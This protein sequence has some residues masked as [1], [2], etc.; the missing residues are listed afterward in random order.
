MASKKISAVDLNPFSPEAQSI[1][2]TKRFSGESDRNQVR[3]TA[4]ALKE[5]G[6]VILK[7]RLSKTKLQEIKSELKLLH[8]GVSKGTS[9]FGGFETERVYNLVARTRALD[10]LYL[11]NE[12]LAIIESHLDDQIQLS[13]SSSVNLLPGQFSQNF[14]RDDGYYPLPR[15][16]M[17]LSV[18]TMWAIDDFTEDNGATLLI[19]KSHMNG[20]EEPVP[21]H[22]TVKAVM[23]AG[24]VM[25]WDGSLFHAGGH[26]RTSDAR[27]GITVIYCRAW[28]RQQENQFLGVPPAFAKNLTRPLQKLIGYWV[29]NNF[30]G[31]LNEASPSVLLGRKEKP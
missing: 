3:D 6:Y 11:N 18:N 15:P 26:N 10:E 23:P 29:A 19:P 2:K 8:E 25:V 5:D 14:H 7:N 13:I 9:H 1:E 12:V 30:L 20:S 22:E 16:H 21:G 28:L 27:M 31:Y 17:P 24:S 4:N